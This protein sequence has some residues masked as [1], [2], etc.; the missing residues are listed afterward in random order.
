[1]RLFILLSFLLCLALVSAQMAMPITDAR[2]RGGRDKDKGRG[3]KGGKGDKGPVRGGSAALQN[4]IADLRKRVAEA[5]DTVVPFKGG[6]LKGLVGLL[7]VNEAIVTLGTTID[8]STKAAEATNTLPANEST[9]IGTQFLGLQ[10]EINNLLTEVQGKRREFDK[11][12]FKILDVRSLI[13]DSVV[14]QKDKAGDLGS[15]FTKALDPTFQ[16][17][18]T[19]I[20][21]QIQNNFSAAIDEYDGRAG[22][23]KI[24]SKAVPVLTDLLAGVARALGIGNERMVLAGPVTEAEAAAIPMTNFPNAEAAFADINAAD[25]PEANIAAQEALRGNDDF[26]RLGPDENDLRGI[27]PLVIAVLRRYEVI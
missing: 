26:S 25:T 17:I 11:A 14:L 6:T 27:P 23:I 5:N 15:A 19:Q 7:K 22:K 3:G 13:R 18:A 20:S 4:R 8:V 12:G 1:M 2:G 21:D 9:Q 10:P 16:P 24:P